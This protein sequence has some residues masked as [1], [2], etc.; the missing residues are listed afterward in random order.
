MT[1]SPFDRVEHL[2]GATAD[3]IAEHDER[4]REGLMEIFAK[5]TPEETDA[6]D[7]YLAEAEQQDAIWLQGEL[8][9]IAVETH[10]AL[11]RNG[12]RDGVY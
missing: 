2:Y 8:S 5:M 12:E 11:E 6:I 9:R 10:A 3:R 1:D 7:A 4:V